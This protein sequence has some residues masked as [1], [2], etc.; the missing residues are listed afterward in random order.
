MITRT[1]IYLLLLL[2][3]NPLFAEKTLG[4]E[5]KEVSIMHN[6]DADYLLEIFNEIENQTDF[7]FYFNNK[8]SKVAKVF[9]IDTGEISLYDLLTELSEKGGVKFHRVN[10]S[11][12][13]T[14]IKKKEKKT[15]FY[16]P[17][18][19]TVT[20]EEGNPLPGAS[21]LEKGT[22]NGTNTDFDGNFSLNV[23]EEDAILV[24]SYIGYE[25]TEVA[26]SALEFYQIVLKPQSSALDEVVV[27]GYGTQEK[28]NVTGAVSKVGSKE[29]EEFPS[30]SVEQSLI[31]KIPGVQLLQSSGQPG[32]GISV[33]VRGLTSI[34]GGNEPLYVVDGVPFFSNDV[35]IANG[36]ASINPNDIESIEVLKDASSTA[37]YGSRGANGVVLITTKSGARDARS[38]VNYSSWVSARNVR[39]KLDLMNGTEFLEFQNRFFANSGSE[40]PDEISQIQN[41]NTDWQDEV[42]QTGISTNHDLS[43]SGG[44]AKTRYY[45]SL[46]SLN[47]EGVITN[48]D[49][50][51]LSFRANVNSELNKIF[52]LK[53]SITGSNSVQN[54]FRESENN[55]TNSI[56]VSGV[57]SILLALPTEPVFNEDGSYRDIS[58]YDFANQVV[59]PVRYAEEI[60]DQTTIRRLIGSLTLETRLA[61]GLS[62]FTR[63]GI[64]YQNRREDG[65]LPTSLIPGTIGR[66]TVVNTEL[67]NYVV[68]NYLEYKAE[69]LPELRLNAVLGGSLQEESVNSIVLQSTGFFTDQLE[70][71]A[72]QAGSSIDIPF[73]NNV[74][75]SIA[76]FFARANFIFKDRYLF[77]ASFRRDGASVFSESN[78]VASFPSLSAGW[79]I[80]E[81]PF[82][83]EN[84][85]ISDLKIRGSW[86]QSGNPG[87]QP[88]QSLPLGVIVTTSQGAGTGLSTGLAP[89]LP[90]RE[91]TWETTTQT[92]IGL[93]LGLFDSRF[94]MSVDYYVKDTEDALTS[95]Q[96]SPSSGFTS[97]IDN[98]GGVQNKGWEL[99]LSGVVI[100]KKDL[101]L[102]L[103]FNISHNTNEVTQLKDNQDLVSE[104]TF[105]QTSDAVGGVSSVARVGEQLGS[106]LG[107]EFLGFDENGVP[108]Y[109]D[110]DEDGN[111][112]DNDKVVI[113]N[114]IPEILYG[115][116]GSFRWKNLTLTTD[117]QGVAKV[118]ILNLGAF[119][120]TAPDNSVNRL[121]TIYQ[122]YPNA[123]QSSEHRMSDRYIENGSFLR[124]RNVKL[125]YRFPI[126]SSFFKDLSFYISGQ[127]L[128][129]I[130]DYSGFDPDINSLNGNDLKQGVDLGAYP[131]AKSYTLGLIVQF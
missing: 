11:I 50:K 105:A 4:Q 10:K 30:T 52:S 49:F 89:N 82:I 45:F 131:A 125:A 111:L 120:L 63:L 51:R 40:L 39:Q 71:N 16:R 130:T 100:E 56:G 58:T 121:N 102:S 108:E 66:A 5:L 22:A 67:M 37:I 13:V 12:S 19:G 126:S 65:Y 23:S 72:I 114:P 20:D 73:T 36:I 127:N 2:L 116:S 101:N 96:L 9:T 107:F 57:G 24:V 17:I 81:E 27:V 48:T 103:D 92:N 33:R 79:R 47:E 115:F 34:S 3:A 87:I 93:D 76:S 83:G 84:S 21:I 75:Q 41:A 68:E 6:Q 91:L 43:L 129:T 46:N 90:N 69:I 118:D 70:N 29:I 31:G 25:T 112:D 117:W 74:D 110:V 97:I 42:F 123:N 106:F 38:A 59:N 7:H 18:R 53:S 119:N 104:F 124:M 113:G 32:A 94:R 78:K 54:G 95:V 1:S 99:L 88:Y 26:I 98:V 77:G 62:N 61:E 85:K 64:D 28:A 35:R 44:N 128:I 122:F 86:G 55:N 80:S 8:V 15:V 14:T 109:L 60:L